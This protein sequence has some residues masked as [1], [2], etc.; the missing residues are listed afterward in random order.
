[1]TKDRPPPNPRPGADGCAV[2]GGKPV[3][4]GTLCGPCNDR[5]DAGGGGR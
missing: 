5:A 2:C 4:S 1:M 3:T